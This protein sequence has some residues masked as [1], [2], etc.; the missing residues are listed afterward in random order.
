[1]LGLKAPFYR[2]I[3]Q[4]TQYIAGQIAEI[5]VAAKVQRRGYVHEAIL[6]ARRRMED[7]VRPEIRRRGKVTMWYNFESVSTCRE[8]MV[9][10][11]HFKADWRDKCKQS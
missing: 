11:I 10:T 5:L 2:H 9:L 7:A 8:P 3:M 4:P 1:M 6:P